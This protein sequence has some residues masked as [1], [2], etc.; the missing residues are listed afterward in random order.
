MKILLGNYSKSKYRIVHRIENISFNKIEEFLNLGTDSSRS[1]RLVIAF[2]R[3]NFPES[4]QLSLDKI[5][6][7]V[8][9]YPLDIHGHAT[10]GETSHDRLPL[11]LY[12]TLV[13]AAQIANLKLRDHAS[14]ATENTQ[15]RV[16]Q[17]VE[18]FGGYRKEISKP[19]EEHPSPEMSLASLKPTRRVRCK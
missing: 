8:L 7:L 5:P 1:S 4:L 14:N 13:R 10:E 9:P 18:A 15:S 6:S 17:I 19:L 11:V 2:H 3:R 12:P 16:Q